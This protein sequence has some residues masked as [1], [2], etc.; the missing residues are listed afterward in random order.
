MST[1][2]T[3]TTLYAT[4]RTVGD[5]PSPETA[6]FLAPVRAWLALNPGTPNERAIDDAIDLETDTIR[7]MI[8]PGRRR[9]RPSDARTTAEQR[10]GYW[11]ASALAEPQPFTPDRLGRL[12]PAAIVVAIVA[13]RIREAHEGARRPIVAV[14]LDAGNDNNGNPRRGWHVHRAGQPSA[15]VEEGYSGR[16][17]LVRACGFDYPPRDWS[18]FN[19]A[20]LETGRYATTPAEIRALRKG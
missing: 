3:T 12:R 7:G 18:A 4:A 11:I 19:A 16:A 14:Y 1:E 2:P 5:H 17:A 9:P 13:E 6:A 8:T 20:V 10:I 15:W